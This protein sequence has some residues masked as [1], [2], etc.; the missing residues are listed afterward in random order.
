MKDIIKSIV[1]SGGG[2][3]LLTFY[4]I[5][6][7]SNK[8]NFWKL[9]QIESLYGTSAGSIL[10]IILALN[11]D[12]DILDNYL[13]NRPWQSVFNIS[14]SSIL[15]IYNNF[16]I[17]S[18]DFIIEIFK[19]LFLSKDIQPAITLKE[20]YELNHIDIHIYTTEIK[21]F[22]YIDIS[23]TT[24]PNWK[25]LDAV[26]ASCAVPLIFY[27]FK[28]ENKYYIDGGVLID[29]P[30]DIALQKYKNEEILGLNKYQILED[31][32]LNENSSILDFFNLLFKKTL[33]KLFPNID[34]SNF[35]NIITINHNM[36]SLDEMMKYS[37][38]KKLRAEL[39]QE[40]IDNFNEFINKD[41]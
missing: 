26:Y 15:S 20:F 24:H 35:K 40:G 2:H 36:V 27:P 30:I 9:D 18:T 23:H 38:D 10:A 17:F 4:G 32:D 25:V 16:G 37:S 22:E 5:L 39:I 41:S 14:A 12:W 3:S 19:S 13:I 33:K 8:N 31:P 34:Y 29:F 1:V 11:I 7:E 28:F 6:K 21:S